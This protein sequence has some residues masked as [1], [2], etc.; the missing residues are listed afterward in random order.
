MILASLFIDDYEAR[1]HEIQE[2]IIAREKRPANILTK[3]TKQM[4]LLKDENA[5]QDSDGHNKTA[6]QLKRIY[7]NLLR[8]RTEQLIKQKDRQYRLFHTIPRRTHAAALHLAHYTIQRTVQ[9]CEEAWNKAQVFANTPCQDHGDLHADTI[10]PGENYVTLASQSTWPSSLEEG[11]ESVG[12]AAPF[13]CNRISQMLVCVDNLKER[14]SLQ[15][16]L[17]S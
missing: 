6:E 17:V 16:D 2:T 12:A 13:F 8:K 14:Y 3:T 1:V 5:G 15:L 4:T 7:G 11:L 9:R 10:S